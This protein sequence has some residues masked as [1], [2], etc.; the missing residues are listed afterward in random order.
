MKKLLSLF[1]LVLFLVG[2]N[3][4]LTFSETTMNH[5]DKGAR[6]FF[7]SVE[8]ENGVYLFFDGEK[9]LYVLLNGKNVIQGDP[10]TYYTD[11]NV[12]AI[13]DTINVRFNKDETDDYTNKTLNNHVLFKINK[14]NDKDYE[15][16]RFFSNGQEIP[17]DVVSGN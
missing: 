14:D 9:A 1:T 8:S 2:C 7:E 12:E 16:I 6:E 10:A 3:S 15:Y 4:G 5:I 11:F 17:I 13:D